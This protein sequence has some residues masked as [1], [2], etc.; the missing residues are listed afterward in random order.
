[1]VY[2]LITYCNIYIGWYSCPYYTACKIHHWIHFMTSVIVRTSFTDSISGII[3]IRAVHVY[4]STMFCASYT[5]SGRELFS[6]DTE[7]LPIPIYAP[8][9]LYGTTC[10][11]KMLYFVTFIRLHV[12][13]I[14]IQSCSLIRSVAWKWIC[15]MNAIAYGF[16]FLAAAKYLYER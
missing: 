10:A 15:S 2:T 5:Y 1:M 4:W 12:Q 13:E 6:I 7:C 14:G 11:Y 3:W 8:H 9:E 16:I